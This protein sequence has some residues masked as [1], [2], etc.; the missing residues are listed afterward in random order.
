MSEFSEMMI[1]LYFASEE[2]SGE[3]RKVSEELEDHLRNQSDVGVLGIWFYPD[4]VRTSAVIGTFENSVANL[5]DLVSF[6]IDDSLLPERP[7]QSVLSPIAMPTLARG[8]VS[9]PIRPKA[10]QQDS[11]PDSP[12]FPALSPLW[13]EILS[14]RCFFL[15]F[16][17]LSNLF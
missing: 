14:C 1:D 4:S 3:I 13:I 7:S 12:E 10:L 16:Y 6:S 15:L 5:A 8:L 9:E 2:L 11:P 17:L